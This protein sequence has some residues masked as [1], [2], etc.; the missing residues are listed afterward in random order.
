MKIDAELAEMDK[1]PIDFSDI[2]P[3]KDE[4]IPRIRFGHERFLKMLPPDILAEMLRRRLE[5][6]ASG[7]FTPK[8]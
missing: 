5:E 8:N 3:M 4:D 2:P 6:I 7:K 1:Y